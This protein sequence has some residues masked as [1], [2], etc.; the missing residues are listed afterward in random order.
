MRLTALSFKL[1]YNVVTAVGYALTQPDKQLGRDFDFRGADCSC[2]NQLK[3]EWLP[4]Q[5]PSIRSS[6]SSNL[7][8]MR[9][10]TKL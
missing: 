2:V 8:A 1:N 9:C 5:P 4:L 10:E 6:R 7:P 3:S